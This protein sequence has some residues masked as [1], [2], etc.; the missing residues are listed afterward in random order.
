MTKEGNYT[1]YQYCH[2]G[3]AAQQRFMQDQ[4]AR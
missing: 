3:K 1:F 2:A 4:Q